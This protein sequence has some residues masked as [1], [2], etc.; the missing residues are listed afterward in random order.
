MIKPTMIKQCIGFILTAALLGV[1]PASA[2]SF[3][4]GKYPGQSQRSADSGYCPGIV[5]H[6]YHLSDCRRIYHDYYE[7]HPEV[8]PN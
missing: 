2:G 3:S 6:V 1:E 4:S 8:R 5:R 7:K